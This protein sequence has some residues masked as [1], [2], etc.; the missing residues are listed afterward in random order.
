MLC[1]TCGNAWQDDAETVEACACHLL[2]AKPDWVRDPP[3]LPV[4]AWDR[5][6]QL[7]EWRARRETRRPFPPVTGP[8]A[9]GVLE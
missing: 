4:K 7:T 5:T 1:R 3:E 2:L 9:E 6:R 8:P